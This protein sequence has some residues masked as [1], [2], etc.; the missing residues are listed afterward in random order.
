MNVNGSRMT[1]DVTELMKTPP[2]FVGLSPLPI[3]HNDGLAHMSSA[4][5]CQRRTLW[6]I[7][8]GTPPR[9]TM[10]MIFGTILHRYVQTNLPQYQAEVEVKMEQY[11]GVIGHA[12]LVS[13]N[14]VGDIKT[15]SNWAMRGILERGAHTQHVFQVL[16]YAYGLDKP[17][18]TVIYVSRENFTVYGFTTAVKPF[19]SVIER[20]LR[21]LQG[22]WEASKADGTPNAYYP[23]P[24][25]Y[26][27]YKPTLE[28]SWC[29]HRDRC[30]E[31]GRR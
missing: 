5:N 3:D 14:E 21:E 2:E 10:P 11:P 17:N 22:I 9:L 6:D 31:G 13:D 25:D 7:K 15:V 4:T 16:L 29:A 19:R 1:N 18:A 12:D 24:K 20:Q 8:L 30:K 27:P 23:I 26:D 28:C